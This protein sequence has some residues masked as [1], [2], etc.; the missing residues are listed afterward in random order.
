M[1]EHGPDP[2]STATMD[3][4]SPQAAI[5]ANNN[6]SAHPLSSI[7][8]PVIRSL[9]Q[10]LAKRP[11]SPGT[12]DNG[13]EVN[14][15]QLFPRT[16]IDTNDAESVR[17]VRQS[18]W[19]PHDMLKVGSERQAIQ[20]DIR[21]PMAVGFERPATI[22]YAQLNLELNVKQGLL[23]MA[24]TGC[25]SVAGPGSTC[26]ARERKLQRLLKSQYLVGPESLGRVFFDYLM[27]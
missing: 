3:L 6:A 23:A 25:V 4:S 12:L 9:V 8:C 19:R 2:S 22:G 13:V 21:E 11:V 15:R 18:D 1:P 7:T 10:D 26:K 27:G 16:L 14:L 24:L 20:Y 17:F 5:P